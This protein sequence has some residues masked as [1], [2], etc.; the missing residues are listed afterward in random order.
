MTSPGLRHSVIRAMLATVF[1]G[2]LIMNLASAATNAERRVIEHLDATF[3]VKADAVEVVALTPRDLPAGAAEYYVE[4]KGSHGHDNYNVVVLGDRVYCSRVEGEFARVLR[5]QAL[6]E[7]KDLSAAQL[8]RLYSLF[9]LPREIK[10]IDANV[11]A[12]NAQDYKAYPQVQPPALAWQP[13]GGVTLTFFTTP[14]LSVEPIKWSVA[15]SRNYEVA[16]SSEALA[17]R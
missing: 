11:L 7:R 5:E 17:K 2:F 6:L 15:I 9:A 10:Y 3:G 8:M 4:A 14:V 16:A 13:D 1:G 12:R